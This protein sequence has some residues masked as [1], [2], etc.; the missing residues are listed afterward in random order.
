MVG[1]IVAFFRPRRPRYN[2]FGAGSRELWPPRAIGL[3]FSKKERKK[4]CSLNPS[5]AFQCHH[6]GKQRTIPQSCFSSHRAGTINLYKRHNL[7]LR[8]IAICFNF[9]SLLL[10]LSLSLSYSCPARSDTTKLPQLFPA[11]GP[12]CPEV[13]QLPA[14][15]LSGSV[16]NV[17]T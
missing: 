13:D 12:E 8:R 6:R 10:P 3:F 17:D 4:K 15:A 11:A 14:D 16:G 9:A 1:I 5:S 7:N 2:R